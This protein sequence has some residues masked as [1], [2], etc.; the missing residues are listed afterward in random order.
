MSD[1]NNNEAVRIR[2]HVRQELNAMKEIGMNVPQSAYE[3][4]RDMEDQELLSMKISDAADLCVT[5]AGTKN[6]SLWPLR[7]DH[8]QYDHVDV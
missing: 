4:L 7:K 1:E 2:D 5:L 6:G 8:Y 3:Y